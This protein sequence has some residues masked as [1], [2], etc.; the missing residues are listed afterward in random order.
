M[1]TT[2]EHKAQT[3]ARV[4]LRY[5]CVNLCS[6]LTF[7]ELCS[8]MCLHGFAYTRACYFIV[9]LSPNRLVTFYHTIKKWHKL[10]ITCIYNMILNNFTSFLNLL[11][12]DHC[13]N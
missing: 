13:V 2:G 11:R 5:G 9:C 8:V 1:L 7:L 6:N 3:R 10:S 12:N 4:E